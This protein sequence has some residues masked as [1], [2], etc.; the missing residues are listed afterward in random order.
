M[1]KV[2]LDIAWPADQSANNVISSSSNT[3][4]NL[5]A[6]FTRWSS[7]LSRCSQIGE[8]QVKLKHLRLLVILDQHQQGYHN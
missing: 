4:P 7:F 8:L 2:N 6:S 3:K 1:L 5:L